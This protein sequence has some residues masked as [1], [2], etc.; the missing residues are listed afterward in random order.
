MR[1]IAGTLRGRKLEAPPGMRTRPLTDRAKETLFNILGARLGLPGSL[2]NVRVLDL[3][4]GSGGLGIEAL[5]RGAASCLFVEHDRRAARVLRQNVVHV[6]LAATAQISAENAWTL[7]IPPV[8]DGYG[9]VFVDPP[10]RE[11]NDLLR[12]VDLLERVAPHL[13]PE[14]VI[15]FRHEARTALPVSALLLLRCVDQRDIGTTRIWLLERSRATDD[16]GGA[17]GAGQQMETPGG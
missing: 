5:S 4:A 1:V 10:Y 8:S 3:F 12:V 6:G 13:A 2:P 14:G 16:W 11:A 17:P 7:R 15:M 9:L